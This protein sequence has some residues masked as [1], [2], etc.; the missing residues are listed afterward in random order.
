MEGFTKITT[1]RVKQN[2]EL[3]DDGELVCTMQ[4]FE[5]GDMVEYE[6][7]YEESIECQIYQYQPYDMVQ[8]K[9]K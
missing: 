8:P 5:A 2:Y 7:D 1:G 6:D 9:G 3:N 4:W